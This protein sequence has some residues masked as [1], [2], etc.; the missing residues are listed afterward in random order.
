MISNVGQ[1]HRITDNEFTDTQTASSA[2]MFE[3]FVF[4][5]I[6]LRI[7]NMIIKKLAAPLINDKILQQAEH[8][9]IATTAL[10]DSGFEF[11]RSRIS[12]KSKLSIVTGMDEPT[13]PGTLRNILKHY[14]DRIIFTIYTRNH[15]HANLYIFDLPFRKS[16]AFI[17]TGHLTLGGIKDQ[18]EIFYR[19]TDIKE[20]EALKSWFTGYFEFGEPLSDRFIEEYELLY[21]ELKRKQLESRIEKREVAEITSRAFSWDSIKFRNQYFKKEDY[22]A[23]SNAK[24]SSMNPIVVQGRE[25]VQKKFADLFNAMKGDLAALNL[26]RGDVE[27]HLLNITPSVDNKAIKKIGLSFSPASRSREES[28]QVIVALSQK[29]LMIGLYA[30]VNQ[31]RSDRDVLK[32]LLSDVDDRK[33]LFQFLGGMGKKY[34]VE[35]AGDKRWLDLF[36]SAELLAEFIRE[37]DARYC[38]IVIGK[39]FQPGDGEIGTEAIA[40]SM[41]SELKK[42]MSLYQQLVR[43]NRS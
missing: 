21:P 17:G 24:A 18:E 14:Q 25:D 16:V 41:A 1:G 5:T 9:Y 27:D 32:S 38:R 4:I 10:S 43:A 29:E 12:T 35:V 28:L 34:F 22:L 19:I 42:L 20:I 31:G 3:L 15:F 36:Q 2:D 39:S 33:N 6:L 23:L 7:S 40:V 37:D 13:S 8:C 11:I 30:D 26:L